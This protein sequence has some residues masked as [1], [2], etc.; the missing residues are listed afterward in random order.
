MPELPEVE[1]AAR[2]ARLALEGRR[3]SRVRVLHRSQRR[4]LPVAAQRRVAGER[5]VAVNRRGK[6]QVIRLGSGRALVVHFRLNGDWAVRDAG[7][8]L[9]PHARVV[10]E[11]DTGAS[12]VLV[13]SRALATITLHDAGE[14]LLA[15][16]GPEANSPAFNATSLGA[17]F[18]TKRG[19]VKPALLDQRKVAGIGNIYASEALWY[20]R[21]D[22]RA[23]ANRLG[24][25]ALRR[26]VLGVKRAMQ[27]ALAHPE[28]YY[29][30][31]GVSDA[32]RFNVYDREGRPCRRCGTPITRIVQTGRSTY[33]CPRCASVR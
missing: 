8:P 7:A 15:A 21:L 2:L 25:A 11:L 5:V 9:P 23:A 14:V 27:K 28:R 13:D 20:A 4:A 16:L 19:P 18:R 17:W 33:F 30:A 32:V 3:I 31:G 10:L 1:Y 29:G 12:L 24:P 22:P 6:Y 26:L